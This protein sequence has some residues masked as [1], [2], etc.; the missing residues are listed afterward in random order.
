MELQADGID[1]DT[2]G[3][4]VGAEFADE[5]TMILPPQIILFLENL[6]DFAE[7][8]EEMFS[9]EVRTTFL[10]E[11]GHFFGLG[12]DELTVRGLQ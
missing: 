4:F 7:G 10:H 9:E 8:N 11:L 3:L 12:E 6:W 2:L 5:G 1:V